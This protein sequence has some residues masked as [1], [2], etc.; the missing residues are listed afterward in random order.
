MSLL[1]EK[2]IVITRKDV[3]IT[4]KICRY[5]EKICCFNEKRSR[6]Y[7]K[8]C[9]INEKRSRYND[10]IEWKKILCVWQKCVTVQMSLLASRFSLVNQKYSTTC[11]VRLQKE[12]VIFCESEYSLIQKNYSNELLIFSKP[13]SYNS[14]SRIPEWMSLIMSRFCS[15]NQKH[16]EQFVLSDSG[17]NDFN[18][19]VLFNEY[20]ATHKVWIPNELF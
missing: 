10:K 11:E 13:D 6:Y 19:S 15:V 9:R 7:E 17:V 5:N 2:Y 3:V 20:S 8:R 16:T 18:E 4:R 14:I 12:S 1:R